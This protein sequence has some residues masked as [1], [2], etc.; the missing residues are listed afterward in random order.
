MRDVLCG[1][2]QN[3]FRGVVTRVWV[4]TFTKN[5]YFGSAYPKADIYTYNSKLIFY[6]QYNLYNKYLSIM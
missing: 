4:Q 6:D 5:N 2:G 3:R 1:F